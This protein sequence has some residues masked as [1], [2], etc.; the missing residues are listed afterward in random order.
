M[1]QINWPTVA[2]VAVTVAGL[3]FLAALHVDAQFLAGVG[4]VG[5]LVAGLLRPVAESPS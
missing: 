4:A 3:V 5:T 2:V 1:T